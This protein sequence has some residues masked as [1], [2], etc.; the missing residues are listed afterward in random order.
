MFTYL[1]NEILQKQ[2]R[3][4]LILDLHVSYGKLILLSIKV[5]KGFLVEEVIYD[6]NNWEQTTDFLALFYLCLVA[7]SVL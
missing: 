4:W 2:L 1:L 3:I 6:A 7:I 5:G